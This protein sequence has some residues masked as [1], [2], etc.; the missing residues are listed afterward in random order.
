MPPRVISAVPTRLRSESSTE[1][2]WV[3]TPA[4]R[5][6]DPFQD[7]VAGQVG[8]DDRREAGGDQ[9]PDG[10]LLEGQVEQDRVVLEEVE[11]RPA[12]LAAGLEVD[13]VE[14]L[15]QGDVVLGLEVEGAGRAD[16]AELAALVLRQPDRGRR[17]G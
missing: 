12:D 6:P 16:L 17:G 13:E 4:R 15:P 9:L 2:T 3:S 7:A 5:E 14:V 11:S 8:R 10:E 1:Y